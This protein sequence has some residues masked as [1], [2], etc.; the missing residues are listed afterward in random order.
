MGLGYVT[1]FASTVK[2]YKVSDNP[3][4]LKANLLFYRHF[5]EAGRR[6]KTPMSRQRILLLTPI[7][8]ATVSIFLY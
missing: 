3:P 5:M 4:Y 2:N 1:S 6:H 8:V 7:T